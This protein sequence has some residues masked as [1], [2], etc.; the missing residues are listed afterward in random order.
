MGMQLT[1]ALHK[2][3]VL[4][5]AAFVAVALW[6]FWASYYSNPLS[7]ATRID[8]WMVHVHALIMSL[9]CLMVVAQSVLI[10]TNRRELHRTVG[11]SSYVLAPVIIILGVIV[12]HDSLGTDESSIV[13]GMISDIGAVRVAVFLV[14][15]AVLFAVLYG[16]AILYRKHSAMHA[17]FMLC[18]VFPLMPPAIDRITPQYFPWLID[19]LP[20]IS[21]SGTLV[22]YGITDVLLLSLAVWDWKSRPRRKVFLA[23]LPIT[24]VYQVFSLS[25]GKIPLWRTFCAWFLGVEST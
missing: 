4:F 12:V 21:K 14:G 9:W 18:T 7:L 22:T 5:F 10:R 2:Y 25:A 24:A 19:Y 13:D 17:R 20:K 11:K 16:L 1:G 8:P 3:S 6:G 15:Q 23:L